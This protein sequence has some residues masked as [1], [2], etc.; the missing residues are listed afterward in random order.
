MRKPPELWT[1]NMVECCK[2]SLKDYHSRNLENRNAES[3]VFCGGP[4]QEVLEWNNI[5]N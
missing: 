1:R 5:T 4:D 2:Q 3:N